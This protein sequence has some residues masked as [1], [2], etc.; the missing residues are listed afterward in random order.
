[1]R[2]L[3]IALPLAVA[4]FAQPA[5]A[6]RFDAASVKRIPP[7]RIPH[8]G[9]KREITPT[10]VSFHTATLGNLF[11]WAFGKTNYEVAG[12]NWLNWPTDAAYDLD[13]RVDSPTAEEQ[14][15]RMLQALLRDRFAL[16]CHLEMRE[17]PVYA[18]RTARGGPK[19]QA[20][21]GE[22]PPAMKP[23]EAFAMRYERFS[24]D[25]FAHA[26]EVPLQ[27]RHVVDE[28]GL[29]GAFDFTLDLSPYILDPETGLAVK[30]AIGRVDE[31]GAL[32]RG[33][34]EQLGLTLARKTMPMANL[35]M[36]HVEKDPTAN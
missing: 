28:T 13:A 32:V 36:D 34:P 16:R 17:T 5:N 10:G 6:P 35:V 29:R 1:M 18:L 22:G 31:L 7:D 4:C 12:P 11:E 20:S 24:M 27:P 8:T 30:D 33:L 14:L 9:L 2:P 19:I 25:R 3:C 23:G 15:K 21:Q 26:L